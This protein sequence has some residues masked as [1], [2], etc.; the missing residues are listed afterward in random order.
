MMGK[1]LLVVNMRGTV[2]TPHDVKKTLENLNIETRFRATILPDE[3]TYR[4][5]LQKAKDHVAWCESNPEIIKKILEKR[6]RLEGWKPLQLENV[7]GLGFENLDKLAADLTESKVSIQKLK[8]V[9]PSF[10]L[11]PPR[12]GFRRSTRR[13]YGQ[14]GVL[15][16]NPDLAKVVEK[17]L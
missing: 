11:S 2:N 10:A 5:M 4:G 13:N 15:G 17:M 6:G 9:K 7:K 16:A 3:P 1:S 14:G 8:G 12:G